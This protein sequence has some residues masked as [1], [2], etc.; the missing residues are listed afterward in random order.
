MKRRKIIITIT[1]TVLIAASILFYVQVINKP[2]L[3]TWI[4]LTIPE[5]GEVGYET[6]ALF[7]DIPLPDIS[8]INGDAKFVSRSNGYFIGYKIDFDIAHLDTTK[9]PK[10]Y[11]IDKPDTVN[12][13]A[14]TA[15]GLKEVTYEISFEF[16]LLD[17][18]GFELDKIK[19][20]KEYAESGKKNEIQNMIEKSIPLKTIELTKSIKLVLSIDK[21]VSCDN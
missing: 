14:T 5:K 20:G 19:S 18:D 21:C 1:L 4:S 11:L 17:K 15:L 8:K 13:V 10:K 16:T 3:D 7:N 6:V 2:R 9:V 12:G